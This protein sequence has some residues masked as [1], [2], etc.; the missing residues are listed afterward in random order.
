MWVVFVM[1]VRYVDGSYRPGG[2]FYDLI[3]AKDH[4]C[5]ITP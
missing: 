5:L 3:A 1:Q 4:L 2:R